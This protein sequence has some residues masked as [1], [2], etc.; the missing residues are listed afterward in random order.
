MTAILPSRYEVLVQ[1]DVR[2]LTEDD[3]PAAARVQMEAFDDYD[4]RFGNPVP[5]VTP[6]RV[7]AQQRRIRHFLVH[8]PGGS[9]VAESGD[10]V[11]GVALALKR[12]RLWGLSLLVVDPAA[13]S[14]GVGRR[15]LEAALSYADPDVPAV[16]LSSRDP[17]A[18]HRYASARFDHY[19][20]TR[21]T[22]RVSA[23]RLQTLELPV[24]EGRPGDFAL[25]DAVDAAVRGAPR[26]PDH[27][28][29]ASMGP[30]FVVDS[31]DRRG[32]AYLRGGRVMTV[33]AGDE[34]TASALLWRCLAH[35]SDLGTDAEVD[36]VAGNQQWA[37]RI[38]NEAGLSMTPAG[39][40]FWR[41]RTPPPAYLPSGAYL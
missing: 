19:P 32:Y 22:G 40:V 38:A 4:R 20:Q 24:R 35:V 14:R 27:E 36:H 11:I 25:A 21:A 16:I 5:D 13:Q 18:M 3:V 29:L 23:S 33:A 15:L 1:V 2:R 9:W 10:R 8:D 28:L 34:A 6:A 7:E 39:P 31:G 17:R 12:A 26:G 30:M 41:G 37:V